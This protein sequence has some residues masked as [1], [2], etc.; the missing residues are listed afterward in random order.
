[1]LM[2]IGVFLLPAPHPGGTPAVSVNSSTPGINPEQTSV[3]QQ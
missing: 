2:C 3:C 1:M